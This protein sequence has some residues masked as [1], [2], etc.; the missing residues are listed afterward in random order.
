M[1]GMAQALEPNP[2]DVEMA[3]FRQEEAP[4]EPTTDQRE[5]EEDD[6]EDDDDDDPDEPPLLCMPPSLHREMAEGG[7]VLLRRKHFG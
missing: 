5:E 3:R 1:K 2:P 7:P 4:I 6:E